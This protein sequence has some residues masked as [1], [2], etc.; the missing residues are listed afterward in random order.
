MEREHERATPAGKESDS[1]IFVALR[2]I[3][4]RRWVVVGITGAAAVGAVIISLLLPAWYMA[5]TRLLL[6]GRMASGLLSALAG[7]ASMPTTASS[8][9]GGISGDYQRY[10][11]ILDSR[12]MKESVVGQFD[13]VVVYDVADSDAPQFRAIEVLSENLAFV[14]DQEYN[15]LSVR[16]FDKDPQ[17][18]ADIANFVVAE[19][20]RRNAAL[21]S[22]NARAYREKVEVR[23]LA[24]EAELDS[25]NNAVRDLQAHSGVLDIASQAEAFMT[26]MV[27]VRMSLLVTEVEHERLLY[28]YGEKNSATR[29]AR[30]A[31]DAV[32][33]QYQAAL[34]GQEAVMPVAQDSLPE[35][36]RQF[37]DLETSRLILGQLV[38][39]I[40]PVLEEAR[41]EELRQIEAV[42]VI[43]AAVPP[44]DK[45]R[46]AR[47]VICV[48]ST[49]SGFMLSVAYVLLLAWWR[50][51]YRTL[52][53]KLS[54]A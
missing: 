17:R 10:L 36:A 22:Q 13:L 42:E 31:L 26:G 9:L 30:R 50:K 24:M 19:L 28:L 34:E 49:A 47:A 37:V 43:D 51:N 14:V 32:T 5:E 1:P 44:V 6:P 25:I 4:Q 18:A 39:Y 7:G 33:A 48:A 21:A 27:E 52:A 12:T 2:T 3:W 54:P 11:S 8:L 35:L 40:R 41:L 38:A 16:A 15:H 20:N 46:P 45:A 23:Y 53:R 29:S